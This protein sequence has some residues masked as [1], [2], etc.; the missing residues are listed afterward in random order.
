MPAALRSLREAPLTRRQLIRG[1][2][3]L[4]EFLMPPAAGAAGITARS[5]RA[6]GTIFIMLEGGMRH[7]DSWDPKP[8]APAEV[9]G[10]FSAIA[11]R[12]PGLRISEHM[13]QLAR[14]AD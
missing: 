12:S 13:P 14:Q 9:R 11:T 10:E 6:R 8:N 5:R 2:F 3:S 4:G 7:L 1:S